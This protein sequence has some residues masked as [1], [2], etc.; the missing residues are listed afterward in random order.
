MDKTIVSERILHFTDIE[1]NTERKRVVE[2]FFSSANFA[3]KKFRE[4]VNILRQ[5]YIFS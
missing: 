5:F 2:F 1:F 3:K 4:N